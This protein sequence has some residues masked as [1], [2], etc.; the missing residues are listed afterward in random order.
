MLRFIYSS[1]FPLL[2]RDFPPGSKEKGRSVVTEELN[3][4]AAKDQEP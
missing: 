2:L 3:P 1:R 4:L